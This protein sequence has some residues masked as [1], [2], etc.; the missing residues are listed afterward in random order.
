[1][2]QVPPGFRV[3]EVQTVAEALDILFS[4]PARSAAP[5]RSAAS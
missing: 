3:K 4:G 2:G 5:L 1:V